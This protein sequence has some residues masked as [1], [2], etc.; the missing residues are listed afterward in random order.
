MRNVL[1]MSWRMDRSVVAPHVPE[2]LAIDTYDGRA[3]IT[4]IVLENVDVRPRG[5]PRVVGYDLPEINVHVKVTCDGVPGIYYFSV[6]VAG[7]LGTVF[8]RLFHHAPYHYA[9][10]RIRSVDDHT[11]VTCKRRHPGSRP[12]HFDATYGSSERT[13]DT[14]VG[15]LAGFLTGRRRFFTERADGVICSGTERRVS[16]P[17]FHS[18]VTIRRSTLFRANGFADPKEDP[19]CYY[20]PG[21]AADLSRC[22]SFRGGTDTKLHAEA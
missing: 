3:W 16:W 15:T 5:F 10:V 7:L 1:F 12:V 2:S 19:V 11:R 20:S 14:E 22:L 18:K 8:P 6:D 17:L 13:V 4:A 9:D 21:V